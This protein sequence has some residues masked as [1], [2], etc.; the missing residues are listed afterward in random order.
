MHMLEI[1]RHLGWQC[2]TAENA[3][4]GKLELPAILNKIKFPL[5]FSPLAWYPETRENGVG[6]VNI[7]CLVAHGLLQNLRKIIYN[8][9]GT[10]IDYFNL[11]DRKNYIEFLQGS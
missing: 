2:Y 5:S 6:L 3:K 1:C 8:L 4:F 9:L 7:E 10:Y 11:K